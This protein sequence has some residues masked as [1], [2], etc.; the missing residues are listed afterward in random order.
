MKFDNWILKKKH[1]PF[2]ERLKVAGS[3]KIYCANSNSKKA[4]LATQI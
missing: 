4:R 3:N 1:M 2:I